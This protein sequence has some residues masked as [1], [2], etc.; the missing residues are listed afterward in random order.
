MSEDNKGSFRDMDMKQKVG[1]ILGITLFVILILSFVIGIYLFG[2]AGIFELIGAE[3][4]SFWSLVIFVVSFFILTSI[5]ELFSKP[6]SEILTGKTTDKFVVLFVQF[7]IQVL[8]NWL[9]LFIVDVFMDSITLSLQAGL[10]VAI[11][12]TIFETA[13]EDREKRMNLKQTG[14]IL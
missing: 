14:A 1:K 8:T 12:L 6:I 4:T 7:I 10:I 2:M 9:C 5:I 13:F 3:Y 11:L